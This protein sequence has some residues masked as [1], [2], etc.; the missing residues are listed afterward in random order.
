MK[1]S[2]K[3]KT[4]LFAESFVSEKIDLKMYFALVQD[5]VLNQTCLNFIFLKIRF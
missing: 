2:R 3:Y 4:N 5:Q 1:I